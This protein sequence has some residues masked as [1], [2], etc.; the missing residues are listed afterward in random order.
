M[1][2]KGYTLIESILVLFFQE[3][4]IRQDILVAWS[5][6]ESNFCKFDIKKAKLL[7]LQIKLVR[8]D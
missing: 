3:S 8:F 5:S 6:E 4:K 1:F 2:F 7:A